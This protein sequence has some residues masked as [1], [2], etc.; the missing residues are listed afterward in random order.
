MMNT[1]FFSQKGQVVL[2]DTTPAPTSN[3]FAFQA[4]TACVISSITWVDGY[5]ATND[6]TDLTSIPAGCVLAGRF[7]TLTLASGEGIAHKE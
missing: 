5:A 1:L 7:K 2:T 6:W 3:Y 4:I